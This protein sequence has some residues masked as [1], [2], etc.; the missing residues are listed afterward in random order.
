M[1]KHN[2]WSKVKHKK[3]PADAKRGKVFTKLSKLI[4]VAVQQGGADVEMNSSLRSAIEKAKEWSVPA[5][6]IERAVKKGSG[7]AK[8]GIR[9]EHMTYE[10]FGPGGV[11]I[12]VHALTDNR[13]RTSANVREA[14]T[15]HG[16]NLGGPGTVAWMFQKKG[17]IIAKPS[18]IP[19]EDLELKLIDAGVEDLEWEGEELL[20]LTSPI[21]FE[22]VLNI[23]K[24]FF[25][26]KSELSYLPQEEKKITSKVQEEEILSLLEI[27]EDDDDVDE[28]FHNAQFSS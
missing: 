16:G 27:L 2:R 6:N 13:N 10:G 9:L 11:A 7:A 5:D 24:P 1:S 28:V 12:Y 3:G 14:F 8:E 17:I 18:G 25:V 23:L 21:V 26:Q 20:V 22:L 4:T 15:K 19:K